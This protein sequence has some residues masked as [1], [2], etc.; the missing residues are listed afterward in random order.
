MHWGEQENGVHAG[1]RFRLE[2][3]FR[4][5]A[6]GVV[7]A[8]IL[9]GVAT[10]GMPGAARAAPV[11]QVITA[12]TMQQTPSVN[13]RLD[14]IVTRFHDYAATWA[15]PLTRL[16]LRLFWLLAGIEFTWSALSLAL[17]GADFSEWVAE[18]VNRIMFIGF[19]LAL[20]THSH[21]WAE[22]IINSFR[23]AGAEASGTSGLL[24]PSNIFNAGV[25][26]AQRIWEQTSISNIGPAI[27]GLIV[28]VVFALL[29]AFVI[30]AL[31]ESYLVVS[32]GVLMM[33]FGGSRWTKD[34]AI[35]IVTYAMSVG[36]KLFVLEL[37]LGLGAKMVM[38]WTAQFPGGDTQTKTDV[39]LIVGMGIV[40]LALAKQIPDTVQGLINGTHVGSGGAL[41]AASA[42]VGGAAGAVA[43]AVT[44]TGAAVGGA[45]KLAREQVA[46]GD[47]GGGALSVMGKTLK[48]LGSEAKSD[49][50]ARLSGRAHHGHMPWRMAT[51]MGDRAALLRQERTKPAAGEGAGT[52]A[53]PAADQTQAPRNSIR[54]AP[55][56]PVGLSTRSKGGRP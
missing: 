55:R 9:A 1:G 38:E 28:L 52:E 48:N 27:G 19:F 10:L 51:A 21:E 20:L 17:K 25:E 12:M 56:A 34:Y 14:E 44:G 15:E 24:S 16:A 7:V 50:G 29:G 22:A 18:L 11:Q 47:G 3:R 37:I 39:L 45:F 46:G 54:P 2:A 4:R 6:A 43:G 35:K 32:A 23:L 41:L 8:T 40:L 30:L 53:R 31:V 36:A 26:L 49:V 33:G 5:V 13:G 42:A